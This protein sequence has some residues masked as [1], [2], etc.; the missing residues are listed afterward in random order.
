MLIIFLSR[1][2]LSNQRTSDVLHLSDMILRSRNERLHRFQKFKTWVKTI[3]REERTRLSRRMFSI[4]IGEFHCRKEV[5][6]IILVII[7]NAMKV[8]FKYLIYL[9]SEEHT[10]ELQSLRHLV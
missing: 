8:L 5:Y 4:V 10:S 3:I 1:L 2:K 6:P 7:D 9:R